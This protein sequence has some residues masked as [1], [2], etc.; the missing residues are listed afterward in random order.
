[1]L[2]KNKYSVSDCASTIHL[3]LLMEDTNL[4][5]H[6]KFI[7]LNFILGI[8][9]LTYCDVFLFQ[10]TLGNNSDMCLFKKKK[11]ILGI[12]NLN[13][14]HVIRKHILIKL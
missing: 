6:A 1:M 11:K 9:A 4:F 5:I 8:Q 14:H 2:K 3:A 12:H 13:S 10:N 7:F